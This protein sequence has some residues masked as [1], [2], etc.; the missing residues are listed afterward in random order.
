MKIRQAFTLIEVLAALIILTIGLASAIGMVMYGV[1]ILKLSIGRASGMATAMTVAVDDAPL[2]L[3]SDP[4]TTAAG[5]TKGYINGFWVERV[6]TDRRILTVGMESSVVHVDVY[7]TAKGRC[8]ASYS[9]RVV[10][11]SP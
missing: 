9:E 6:E 7:E 1:Q 8:V 4:W 11:Q 3:A 10:R 5:V 2:R